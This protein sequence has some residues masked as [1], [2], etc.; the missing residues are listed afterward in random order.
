MKH[1]LLISFSFFPSN[2]AKLNELKR[3]RM[4]GPMENNLSPSMEFG[5]SWNTPK[6]EDY[7]R[8]NNIK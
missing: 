6:L 2:L 3:K 1:N 8:G 7:C 5:F 4:F